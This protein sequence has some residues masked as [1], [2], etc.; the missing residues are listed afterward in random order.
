MAGDVCCQETTGRTT[1]TS[2][3]V[4][5]KCPAGAIQLCTTNADCSGTDVC[6]PAGA[7]YGICAA[8]PMPPP[9]RDGGVIF[10]GD[11]GH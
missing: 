1:S 3:C 10:R 6:R 8:P 7:D 9:M 11:A 5:T 4:A 2:K